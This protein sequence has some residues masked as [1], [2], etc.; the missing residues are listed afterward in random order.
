MRQV[1]IPRYGRPEVLCLQEVPDPPLTPDGVRIAVHASGVNFADVL[2]RQGLYPDCPKP[3]VVVGY[4]VAGHVIET[5]AE[6]TGITSGQRVLALTRFGGYADQ[7]VV[8]SQQVFALP[9]DMPFTD[10]A[11]LPTN[12]LTAYLMLY[13]C[14][15]LQTGEHVLIHGGAGGVG[16][17]A[18][19]L[20]RLR[21]A[22][23]YATASPHKH[24]FLQEQGV[25][26]TFAYDHKALHQGIQTATAGRGVDIV[27][28]PQGGRSFA[29]SYRLL[30]PLGRLILFGVSRLSPGMRRNP[31]IALWH[32][33][34]MPWFH[35]IRLLND[36]TAVIG[37]N[38]GHLWEQHVLLTRA[39]T[40][41]LSLYQQ[42]LIHPIIARQFELSETSA[43]HQYMQE[44]QNIGKI[45]LMA[46]T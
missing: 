45:I 40:E 13:V 23:I 12:Y 1:C 41:I 27:L 10:A 43:A 36:N 20:C 6:A 7:V 26:H 37:V 9:D 33:L 5:G 22:E 28:D 25:H 2:A 16:L 42:Q 3:P 44:R 11:A 19:Q 30:A 35:P 14:G 34:R 32:L 18:V 39:M 29:H 15:H 4:E 17:A 21:E 8:P 31:L 46:N 38:L 24:I